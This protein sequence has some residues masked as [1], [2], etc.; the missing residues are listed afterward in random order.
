M[1]KKTDPQKLTFEQAY[2]ELEALVEELESG[3]LPLEE[4]ME[5]FARGQALAQRCS[6]LLEEAELK[7]V[8]LSQDEE[9]EYSESDFD[10]EVEE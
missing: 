6:Q 5:T 2:T 8:S 3:D 10:F 1:A 9:G 7:L 4:S